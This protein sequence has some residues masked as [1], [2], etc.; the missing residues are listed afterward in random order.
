M[1]CLLLAAVLTLAA[2]GAPAQTR[3]E[4]VPLADVLDVLVIDRELVAFDAR[5]G[6]QRT[7][8][9]RLEEDVIWKGVRGKVGVVITS[10]RVLAIAAGSGA[11]QSED[12]RREEVLPPNAI[13]GDRVA[14]VITSKR[15]IGFDGGTG[16][17][18]ETS[19]GIREVVLGSRTGE[20]VA[21][22]ATDRRALGLSPQVGGF[23]PTKLQLA[24]R[25]ESLDTSANLATLT[26]NRRIL[27]FRAPFGT[28]EER[29]RKLR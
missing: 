17:L 20:N 2:A 13:L 3:L 9:L 24:E 19:L 11:W 29:R 7:V 16:N 18:L 6:G 27:I 8:T 12:K 10:Q 25:V 14:L 15:A 4:D 28:W 23:F 1:R 22:V 26:T 21:V 5:S